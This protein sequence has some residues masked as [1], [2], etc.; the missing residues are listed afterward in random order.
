MKLTKKVPLLTVDCVVI[1]K[2]S[3]ILIKRK[4]E[5]FQDRKSVV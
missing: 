4:N 1:Y 5:P 3:I 2:G